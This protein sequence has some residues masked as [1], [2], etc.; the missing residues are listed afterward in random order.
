MEVIKNIIQ[1]YIAFENSIGPLCIPISFL[2]G[3][4]IHQF[5]KFIYK[6]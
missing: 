6:K 1:S 2:L 3:F 5:L 4:G